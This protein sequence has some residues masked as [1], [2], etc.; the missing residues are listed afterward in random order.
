MP[1]NWFNE[2]V[3][4]FRDEKEEKEDSQTQNNS[5]T[6]KCILS[7]PVTDLNQPLLLLPNITI[8]IMMPL[9]TSQSYIFCS[10]MIA[11]HFESNIRKFLTSSW[12]SN[13]SSISFRHSSSLFC[14]VPRFTVKA[15]QWKVVTC[16]SSRLIQMI[17]STDDFHHFV[18]FFPSFTCTSCRLLDVCWYVYLLFLFQSSSK[19]YPAIS[20]ANHWS[21]T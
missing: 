4:A 9:I 3:N 2:F 10:Q 14:F 12:R 19:T 6:F 18:T 5:L 1:G 16:L 11:I 20:A 17:R 7:S 21:T 13:S 8:I 15:Y